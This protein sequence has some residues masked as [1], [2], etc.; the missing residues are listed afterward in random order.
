MHTIMIAPGQIVAIPFKFENSAKVPPKLKIYALI[1]DLDTQ[2]LYNALV[3][4]FE[5][6][7]RR[8]G[9]PY[10]ITLEG[11]DSTVQY[12]STMLT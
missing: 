10:K 7:E 12:S 1:Q 4:E 9:E 11:F 8:W 6:K 3:G 5:L 2:D